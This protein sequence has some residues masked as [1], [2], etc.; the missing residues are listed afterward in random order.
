MKSKGC[1]HPK[2]PGHHKSLTGI[3]SYQ[4]TILKGNLHR[5]ACSRCSP[6]AVLTAAVRVWLRPGGGEARL[7]GTR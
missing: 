4:T 2:L 6:S 5:A 1:G 7:T 3:N